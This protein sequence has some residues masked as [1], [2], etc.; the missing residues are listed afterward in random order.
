VYL[1]DIQLMAQLLNPKWAEKMAEQGLRGCIRDLAADDGP[2]GVG[3]TAGF[4]EDWVYDQ[5]AATYALDEAMSAK[6]R[7]SNPEAFRNILK[8]MLEAAGRGMW[9][10]DPDT[11]A[12]LQD[13]FGAMDDELEGV[14]LKR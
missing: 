1:Y 13:A 10:A 5:A 8:R 2:G 11:L 12:K 3:G 7:K 4:E 14:N 6:L 9:K